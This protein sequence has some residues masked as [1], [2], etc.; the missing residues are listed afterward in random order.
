MANDSLEQAQ[1]AIADNLRK[2]GQPVDTREVLEDIH[3]KQGIADID[4]REAIWLLIGKG[5]IGLTWD[6]KLVSKEFSASYPHRGQ[7]RVS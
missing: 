6:R 1:E 2:A 7:V 5:E 3:R 4:L